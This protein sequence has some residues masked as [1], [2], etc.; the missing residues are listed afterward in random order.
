[1]ADP[2]GAL[3]ADEHG[4]KGLSLDSRLR[5][6]FSLMPPEQVRDLAAQMAEVARR[7]RMVYMREGH[8]EVINLMLRPAGVMPDQIAYFHVVT[9]AILNALKRLPDLYIQDFAI[10]EVVPLS[11]AEEKWLWD[12]WGPSHRDSNPVFGR[13]DAIVDF[14]SPV[15][16]DTLEFVEPN[17]CGVGGIHL[18]PTCEHVLEEVVVPS[19][20]ALAPDVDIESGLDLREM[21][22][23]EMLDHLENIGHAGR[24]ISSFGHFFVP[25]PNYESLVF[26]A[27]P[28]LRAN[29]WNH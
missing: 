19:I 13:L 21:F 4:L 15:W 20:Q 2:Q 7:Q 28:R 11:A 16:K 26:K 17:L 12:T 9:L 1:M 6:V 29:P 24:N 5:Q 18:I 22:I 3:T 10:R 8:E 23:Q 25:W 27:F 14:T